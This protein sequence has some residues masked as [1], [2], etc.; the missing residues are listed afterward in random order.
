MWRSVGVSNF[1]SPFFY[2]INPQQLIPDFF[3]T[4][5]DAYSS[6][7][8]TVYLFRCGC[9]VDSFSA[10][11]KNECSADACKAGC[12]HAQL[13]DP[14]FYPSTPQDEKMFRGLNV[15]SDPRLGKD[16]VALMDA[17]TALD[18]H[19]TEVTTLTW[20]EINDARVAVEVNG[21]MI[22]TTIDLINA[23]LLLIE[24]YDTIVG[25]L[26]LDVGQFPRTS[27]TE[28]GNELRRAIR[29]VEQAALEGI[30]AG[31]PPALINRQDRLYDPIVESCTDVLANRPWGSHTKF[32]GALL[33]PQGSE[34]DYVVSIDTN[35]GLPWGKKVCY[36]TD[37]DFR[38]TGFYLVAGQIATVTVPQSVVDH[39]MFRIQ[40]KFPL[41]LLT[42]NH[43]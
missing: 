38:I 6:F 40:G 19:V 7:H 16:P 14:A 25:P 21:A 5:H 32:P 33:G 27:T 29:Q 3:C 30:Y 23:A 11:G 24:N 10:G 42:H 31:T 22:P 9:P 12:D 8:S 1:L 17:L 36:S 26:F 41:F 35:Y 13:Q 37:W 20:E 39:G 2:P 34:A 28:D 43:F 18:N 15:Q 4:I